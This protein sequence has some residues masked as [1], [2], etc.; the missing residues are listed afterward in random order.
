[1]MGIYVHIP[2]CESKCIY[3]AFAS[4]VRDENFQARYF[5]FLNKEIKNCNFPDRQCCSIYFGGGTPSCVKPEKIATILN[6]IKSN[7]NVLEN[8]EITIEC[9]PCSVST[10]KL[11]SYFDAGFNRISFGVQ[12]LDESMLKFLGR[13]H[14][15]AQAL[16][17]IGY[18]KNAG[19][20]NISA[21][22]LLGLPAGDVISDAQELITAGVKHI[23]A[24][25]LQ[26]EDGTPLKNMVESG[27]VKLPDDD[28][29]VKKYQKLTDFLQKN[30]FLQYEISNFALKGFKSKH[31]YAYWTGQAYLGFG[32]GAHSFDGG[33]V[34][35][36][37]A[38]N[39]E[40]YFLGKQNKEVLSPSQRDE[41]VIMLGLRCDAG[42]RLDALNASISEKPIF[43]KYVQDGILE[44]SD[45]VIRLNSKY[46]NVSNS[47]ILHL[48]D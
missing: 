6:T 11:S 20:E 38:D 21:D 32:L 34:R 30:G 14:T 46:Y 31:N 12:S 2:F 13:R 23:S 15:K 35:W 19:F 28:A 40:D 25:M 45:G 44:M 5:E 10:Q 3:C 1:M 39:F 37:N 43:K 48:I 16:D 18:A 27:K 7:F 41:E 33:F 29:V 17:A 47:I 4:F 9:N 36:A 42:F 24:Y 22:L 8:A 26:V